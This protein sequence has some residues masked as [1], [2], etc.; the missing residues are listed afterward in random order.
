MDVILISTWLANITLFKGKKD[1][2]R[3][4]LTDEHDAHI[5]DRPSAFLAYPYCC[6]SRRRDQLSFTN[7]PRKKPSGPI[8]E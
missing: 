6:V 1:D 7:S 5:F 3:T 8:A 2:C 4:Y